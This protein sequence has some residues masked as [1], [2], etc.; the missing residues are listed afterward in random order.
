M[1]TIELRGICKRFGKVRALDGVG[2]TVESREFF[3]IVGPTNAG[4][5][6]TLRIIAGLE[7]QDEG[8]V[9]FEGEKVND[10]PPR[11]RDT[12]MLFQNLAL[13]PN[14]DGFEN[15]AT[16]LRIQ[17][18]PEGEV[19]KRVREVAEI[20]HVTHLLERQPKTFSGGERQRI[21]IGRVIIRRPKVYLFDEPLSNLDAVLRVEM[22]SE[23]K[24]LQKELGQTTIYVTHDQVEALSMSDRVLVL[25]KGEVQQI[26]PPSQVYDKPK[27]LF[28]AGFFGSPPMNFMSCAVRRENGR[29]V[30][31]SGGI[32]VDA[33]AFGKHLAERSRV[34]LGIRPQHVTVRH[35]GAAG[36]YDFKV[37]A[38]EL[39]GA[40]KILTFIV[41]E[42]IV[43]AVVPAAHG[44][45]AGDTV[46]I[47]VD[48]R[49]IYVFDEQTKQVLV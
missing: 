26:G 42:A 21:A 2:F 12:A 41:G 18:R 32:R 22:R 35:R 8:D 34:T 45:K 43:L 37:E 47:A 7:K 11:D 20:L 49:R 44:V 29:V 30:L 4:K 14:K 31:E 16:P 24:R 19:K 3:C 48:G 6:T 1:A 36:G 46:N 17:N 15:I 33:S 5:T 28:T 13:Y 40:K 38:V 10:V 27:N 9:L 25:N 23:L 39:L